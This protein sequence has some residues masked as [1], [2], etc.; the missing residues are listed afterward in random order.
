MDVR[1]ALSNIN[2]RLETQNRD[3]CERLALSEGRERALLAAF[4]RLEEKL[5]QL[6]FF[7]AE[8]G[9]RDGEL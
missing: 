5:D 1:A 6:I 2:M 4:D 9:I 3:L 8:D 7:Q